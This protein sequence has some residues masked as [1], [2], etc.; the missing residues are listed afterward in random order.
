MC[1]KLS[2]DRRYRKFGG[3]VL[4]TTSSHGHTLGLQGSTM[5]QHGTA[6]HTGHILDTHCH[7]SNHMLGYIAGSAKAEQPCR[8]M[9]EVDAGGVCAPNKHGLP[10]LPD[11][12]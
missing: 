5:S 6:Q 9:G 12:Y 3:V 11:G 1:D 4:L 8:V 7:R 10:R 2:S